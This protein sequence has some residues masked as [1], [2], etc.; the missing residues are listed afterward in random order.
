MGKLD[1]RRPKPVDQMEY[2]NKSVVL[3]LAQ[4]PQAPLQN[5]LRKYPPNKAGTPLIH[6]LLYVV[7]SGQ[8]TANHGAS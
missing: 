6:R 8:E 2:L 7:G 3:L 5:V 4:L 1:V